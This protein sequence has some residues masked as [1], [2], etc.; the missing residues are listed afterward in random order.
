MYRTIL[1]PLDGSPFAEHA[2]PVALS[3]AR[4]TGATLEL[5]HAHTAF[6]Y[7]E[8]AL[9]YDTRLDL[10]LRGEEQ[11]YLEAAAKRLR[12]VTSLKVNIALRDAPV[13][14]AIE[15]QAAAVGA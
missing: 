12:A 4:R 7:V 15:E 11:T 2:L 3:I 1:V 13:A 8:S 6:V 14:D 9:I 5:M 10:Q